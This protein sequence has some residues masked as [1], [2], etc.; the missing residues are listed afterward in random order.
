MISGRDALRCHLLA[1]LCVF[2]ATPL[3]AQSASDWGLA[4][5]MESMSHVRRASASFT[6]SHTAPV[7]SAPL[8]STGTLTYGAPDYLR[9]VTISPVPETFVLD[10][11]HVTLTGGD[12]SGIHEFALNDDPRIAGL[13]EGIRA[14]LAGDLPALERFYTVSLNGEAADWQ[15]TLLPTDLALARHVK[16][17]IV[18]G[19]QGRIGNIDTVS[20]DGSESRMSIRVDDVTIAP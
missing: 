9:K 18:S 11:E 1:A 8:V 6:E 4:S 13:I 15:L 14:T 17:I 19:S 2:V 10:H 12:D 20:S 5:L 16:S 3:E 7:L